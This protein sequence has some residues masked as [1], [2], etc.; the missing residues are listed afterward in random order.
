MFA[1]PR[2]LNRL[3]LGRTLIERL[4]EGGLGLALVC[5]LN[6]DSKRET[7]EG[8]VRQDGDQYHG[9]TR[10]VGLHPQNEAY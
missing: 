4:I 7:S 6:V 8:L 10:V 2:N 1:L 3:Q 9:D 5:A